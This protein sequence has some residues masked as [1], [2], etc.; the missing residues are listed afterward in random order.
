MKFD[1]YTLQEIL[2]NWSS[3]EISEEALKNDSVLERIRQILFD[4]K[5]FGSLEKFDLIPLIR[6][7]LLLQSNN[8]NQEIRLQISGMTPWPSSTD[9]NNGEVTAIEK[10]SPN[11][12]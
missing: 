5:A 1:F 2:N 12:D 4:F 3:V 10:E 6:Q 8:S 7:V 9:W 11:N